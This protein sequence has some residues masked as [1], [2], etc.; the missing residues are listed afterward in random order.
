MLL[1]VVN[2]LGIQ[3]YVPSQRNEEEKEEGRG[4]V[5]APFREQKYSV[6]IKTN[7]MK[8]KYIYIYHLDGSYIIVL[9]FR[10]GLYSSSCLSFLYFSLHGQVVWRGGRW[11]TKECRPMV[12]RGEVR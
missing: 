5:R 11:D 12:K 2:E 9:Y 7:G 3:R 6:K 10:I 4:M 8:N 1:E